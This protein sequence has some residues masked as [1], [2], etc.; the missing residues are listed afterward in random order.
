MSIFSSFFGGYNRPG[1]GVRPDEPR[2]KGI[3]RLFE[4]LG[5]DFWSFF[6][7]GF[8]AAISMIPFLFGIIMAV[9]SHALI[10]V[11]IARFLHGFQK[12]FHPGENLAIALRCVICFQQKQRFLNDFFQ[13]GIFIGI[14]VTKL[15]GVID[16]TVGAVC[17]F[18]NE[19]IPVGG[20][21]HTHT[22]KLT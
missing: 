3:F 12:S 11:F 13:P 9:L 2:K 15:D 16:N 4:I 6:K 21:F 17:I 20:S 10:F 19:Q 7:A 14:A 5:R 18:L 22:R 8:L 1:P